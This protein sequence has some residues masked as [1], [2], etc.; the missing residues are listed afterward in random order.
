MRDSEVIEVLSASP[1]FKGLTP[2]RIEKILVEL[3]ARR[4]TYDAGNYLAHQGEALDKFP[5]VLSGVVEASIPSADHPQIVGRFGVGD[6]FAEAVPTTLK[7]SP[8]EIKI[9]EPAEILFIPAGRLL[10]TTV[11][12]GVLVRANIMAEMSKKIAELSIKLTLLA[13]PR[14][15]R[16]IELYFR[17]LVAGENGWITLRYNRRELASFL[18]VNDKALTRE[19]RRMQDEGYIELSGRKVHVLKSSLDE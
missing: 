1:A 3:S 10:E 19:L 14:L 16:R 2:E 4:R 6:S 18:G 17:S 15:R 8:V 5:I 7:V 9:I 12:D 11:P 13:E